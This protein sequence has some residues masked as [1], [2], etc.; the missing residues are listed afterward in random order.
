MKTMPQRLDWY[1]VLL[2][3]WLALPPAAL[4]AHDGP[5]SAGTACTLPRGRWEKGLFQPLRYGQTD[6]LEWAVHPLLGM[7][8]PNF[9]VKVAHRQWH[10]WNLASRYSFH[11]PTP[12]L[13]LVRRPDIGGLISPE[14]DI[15]DIPPILAARGELLATRALNP[16]LQLTGRGGVGLA[17]KSGELDQRAS[18]DLP[19]VYPRMALYYH[20]YQLNLGLNLRG[21]LSGKWTFS[22]DGNMLMIPGAEEAFAFELGGW[23]SWRK[24]GRFRLLIGYLLTYA[25]YPFG[26]HWQ[27]MPF[28]LAF[29]P[30]WRKL[31][32]PIIDLQWARQR[33]VR[34]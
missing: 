20:G 4:P 11:Y 13:R 14:G 34:K 26:T 24:N 17:V 33:R 10:G 19:L 2:G 15:A 9:Q 32:F 7:V 22:V 27:L 21:D 28:P 30:D 6:R 16:F 31:P 12:L 5:W 18:I 8:L 29:G 1:V 23:L 25:D 3:L